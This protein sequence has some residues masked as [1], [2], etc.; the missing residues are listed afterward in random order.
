MERAVRVGRE[1]RESWEKFGK[2]AFS[3]EGEKKRREEESTHHF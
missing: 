3:K 2:P 1:E